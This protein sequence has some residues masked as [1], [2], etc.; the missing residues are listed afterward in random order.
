MRS[1]SRNSTIYAGVNLKTLDE[2][3]VTLFAE[4]IAHISGLYE[5]QMYEHGFDSMVIASGEPQRM[6]LDDQ[7]Y[8]FRSNP[9]FKYWAPLPDC[10]KSF[11]VLSLGLK[12][13]MVI[14]APADFW[15]KS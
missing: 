10:Q 11:I 13:L 6:F 5:G 12:P 15:E 2:D 7:Y 1:V 9:H 8:T 3:N 14:Y 4:H